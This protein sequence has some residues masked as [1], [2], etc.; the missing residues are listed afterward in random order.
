MLKSAILENEFC[1]GAK[2]KNADKVQIL[3]YFGF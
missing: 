1:F 2:L 3:K